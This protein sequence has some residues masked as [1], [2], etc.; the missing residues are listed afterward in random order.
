MSPDP[1]PRPRQTGLSL[2]HKLPLLITALLVVTMV[3]GVAFAYAEVKRNAVRS[4]TDRLGLVSQQLSGLIG[5]SVPLRLAALRAAAESP[6]VAAFAAAPGDAARPAAEAALRAIPGRNDPE[7][8]MVLL[9]PARAPILRVGPVPD[10]ARAGRGLPGLPAALPDSTGPGPFFAH[11]RNAYFWLVVPVRSGG[12]TVAYLGEMRRA[13]GANTS[14]QVQSLIGPEIEVYFA[15]TAGGPWV[16][17]DGAVPPAPSRWPFAGAARYVHRGR[18]EHFGHSAP[19]PGT[20]WSMVVEQP[21]RA[22]LERPD[23]FLRRSAVAALLLSLAGA[24]GAWLLSRSITRPVRALRLASEAIAKGDYARRIDLRRTDE[25]G[26]LA[27]RFNWM[28]GQVQAT[29]AELR[30]QYEMAQSLA[31]EL[32]QSNHQ[33]EMTAGEAEAAREEAEGANRAKSEFLATMSHEIR[34]PINAIIGYTELLQLGLSGPVTEKQEGQLDRIQVSGRHLIGLVD[35]VLDF[36]RIESGNLRVE[37]RPAL[38]ADAV[39]TALTVLRPQAVAKG[40]ELSA[41]C[42]DDPPPRYLGDSGRVDQILVN[43]LS[44]AIKFTEPGG[45]TSIR[46]AACDGPLPGGGAAG[47]WTCVEVED[48]GVGIPPEEIERVF[49][50][51]VQVESGYTRRHGGSGLGLAI[52]MRLARS[53]GGDLTVRSEPG[54]GSCFTLWLPAAAEEPAVAMAG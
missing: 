54:R 10:S 52:S 35:Q 13:G 4:A 30:D 25:L 20:P 16:A 31:E 51:F 27:D 14:R 40:I 46:C 38:A 39:E 43:L 2:E 15:N 5:S 45:R 18:T 8:P 36:A 49:E 9:S 48:T 32:E 23:T 7:L 21:L 22:V 11:G 6:A 19:I 12:A 28:A 24:A 50:P 34:T 33:L 53:M 3:V 44:N 26:I 29:H 37:R 47:R 17:L 1:S 42:E 41:R